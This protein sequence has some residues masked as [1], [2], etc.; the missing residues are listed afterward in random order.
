MPGLAHTGRA[1]ATRAAALLGLSLLALVAR[2]E[3]PARQAEPVAPEVRLLLAGSGRFEVVAEAG[4]D[5]LRL[6]EWGAAA[7]PQWQRSLGLPGRL[8]VAITVRLLPEADRGLGEAGWRVVTEP[9]GVITVWIRGGG[10]A[11]SERERR[12]LRALAE[13]VL[14]RKAVLLGADPTRARPPAW[15][16]A[17]AAES[18]LV[19]SRPA[20][21]DAWQSAMR[22]SEPARLRDILV[23]G[24]EEAAGAEARALG[25][26]GVWLWLREEGARGGAWGRFVNALLRGESPGSALAREYAG[27]TPR[28]AEAREWELAWRVAAARLVR[29]H[30]L[31]GL[32]PE[33]SRRRLEALSRI[34]VLDTLAGRERVLAEAEAWE[35]RG[36]AWPAEV[37]RERGSLLA[38]E[39]L[40]FHPFYRNAAGSLG[41]AWTALAEGREQ[42]WRTA[43]EEWAEDMASGRSLEEASRRLLD[44]AEAR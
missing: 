6:A 14:V 26:H 17:A 3:K 13:G 5:G 37:R 43:T 18:V 4:A 11:G 20:A 34:V 40:R 44:E 15:L 7:W 22:R 10:D 28:P 41:R 19:A 21:L 27:L 16:A 8:P 25:A 31:P 30:T 2:A 9:G 29:A 24:G 35:T 1:R 42:E 12:W 33:E 38:A 23:P 36:E 32:E 39:Y